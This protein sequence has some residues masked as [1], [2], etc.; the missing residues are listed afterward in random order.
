MKKAST[1]ISEKTGE[2]EKGQK[3]LAQKIGPVVK[4]E[5]K[6][7]NKP[8]PHKTQKQTVRREND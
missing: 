8:D 1:G 6:V 5:E 3:T 4:K 7:L 2:R